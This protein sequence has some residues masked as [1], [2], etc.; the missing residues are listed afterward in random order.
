MEIH[1]ISAGKYG[2]DS[3]GWLSEFD[4]LR[5]Y[6]MNA[7]IQGAAEKRPQDQDGDGDFDDAD[8]ELYLKTVDPVLHLNRVRDNF[9]RAIPNGSRPGL[10]SMDDET[11]APTWYTIRHGAPRAV[12][13]DMVRAWVWATRYEL[14][15][16]YGPD[17][18]FELASYG[19][20]AWSSRWEHYRSGSE[21]MLPLLDRFDVLTPVYYS[22][23]D[24]A[25]SQII[26][27]RLMANEAS[28]ISEQLHMPVVFQLGIHY[29]DGWNVQEGTTRFVEPGKWRKDVETLLGSFTPRGI[30]IWAGCPTQESAK[31]HN[32]K[33]E[34]VYGPI[35]REIIEAR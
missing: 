35:L 20:P 14:R 33:M 7:Q 8:A 26:N 12:W 34:T 2:T 13:V 19:W 18:G 27:L 15:S 25:G 6:Q 11:A 22:R 23:P 5:A 29:S 1:Q 3:E 4:G 32:E 24:A 10:V 17:H 21:A 30:G 16:R 9:H 31:L 28:W